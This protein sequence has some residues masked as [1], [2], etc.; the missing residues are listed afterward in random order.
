MSTCTAVKNLL[1]GFLNSAEHFPERPALVVSRQAFTYA[2][3]R[4]RGAEIARTILE[5]DEDGYPLIA[6]LAGRSLTAY[7]GIIGTLMTGKGYV[8]L[9]PKFPVERT[10]RMLE[11]SGCSILIIGSE[12]L[13]GLPHLLQSLNRRLTV[14]LPDVEDSGNLSVD[15]PYC[16]IVSASTLRRDL[17]L[18]YVCDVNPEAIAYLLFT[19]GSTGKPKGVPISQSNVNAYLKYTCARYDIC[20]ED[21]IS[22]EFDLTFDLSIHDLF[23]CW[24]RGACLFSVPSASVIAPAKFIRDNQLTMWFSVPSVISFLSKMNLLSKNSFPSLRYSLFCGEPLTSGQAS[25][26]QQ[27][28]LNSVLENLY[29]PTE[30]T[31]AISNYRWDVRSSPDECENGIVPIGRIFEGQSSRII[32]PMGSEVECGEA[33]ELCLGGSQVASGYWKDLAK[34]R[35]RFVTFPATGKNILYRTGDMA[36]RDKS[37][38]IYYLGRMDQQV[39]IRGHRVELQEVE[40]VLRKACATE[41]VVAV[42]RP[43]GEGSADGIVAFASGITSIDE[44]SV[45]AACAKTLPEYMVPRNIVLCDELPLNSNGKI[46]RNKLQS[47]LASNRQ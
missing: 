42:A 32:D 15:F 13:E 5:R 41:Q 35:E 44:A 10:R 28:A 47:S 4:Q 36:K 23:V 31:I 8:P 30:T 27:A 7:A 14:L 34:T 19:S 26:W 2:Q 22:Q 25:A 40:A 33:G 39:K 11:A 20:E 16:N 6:V 29:G 21:R 12:C 9:N 46:D 45:L 1:S 24:E 17:E 18:D 3:L 38:C 43:N 37:G